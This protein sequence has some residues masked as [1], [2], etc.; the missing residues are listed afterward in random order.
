VSVAAEL[1]V[2]VVVLPVSVLELPPQ[3][4]AASQTRDP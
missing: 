2:V 3:H 1:V 4:R